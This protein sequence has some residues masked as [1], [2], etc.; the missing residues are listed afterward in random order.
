MTTAALTLAPW[1]DR[2]GWD[3]FVSES[4]TGSIFCASDVLDSL[5]LGWEV[6]GS[7]SGGEPGAAAVVIREPSGAIARAP[8]PFKL[9]QG[10]VLC[11]SSAQGPV[12]RRVHEALKAT[13][14]LLE[15]ME[16]LGRI[17]WCLHPSF[18]DLR[19]F[20]WFH[21]HEPAKGH[22]RIDLRYTGW[23]PL[24]PS[25]GLEGFLAGAR[26]VRRQEYRKA[27]DRFTVRAST[28]L[29]LLD[30]L[31][32]RTFDRQ[33]VERP[34]EEGR[35]LRRI[36]GHAIERGYGELLVAEDG[37]G[38]AAAATLFLFDRTSGY[39]LVAANDPDFRATGVSTLMLV[40][41]VERSL[42]RGCRRV[43][44]VGMNSPSRGDFKTSF[45]ALPMPYH[46]VHWERP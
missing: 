21:Y 45:G 16:P 5:G 9:Y 23:I 38:R 43:D 35:L 36:A 27:R 34:P 37:A 22:F 44:V 6:R 7:E 39:Y 11:P 31:H 14:A 1:T 25:A 8:L 20:S 15:A 24:D 19:A 33:G 4:P 41:G 30:E 3:R 32:R 18:A 10:V 13:A 17:S 40:S 29:D 42:A 28:D 26:S 2:S 12:H 46:V